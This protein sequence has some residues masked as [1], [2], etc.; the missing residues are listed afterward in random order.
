MEFARKAQAL[1]EKFHEGQKYG[2]Y[3][4][5]QGH[6]LPVSSTALM[7]AEG[8]N[9]TTYQLA[10]V[11][12]AA[13]LHDVVEDTPCTLVDIRNIPSS[14]AELSEIVWALTKEEHLTN[15]SYLG[16]VVQGGLMSILIKLADSMCNHRASLIDGNLKRSL[17]YARNIYYLNNALEL[18][19][20]KSR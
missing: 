8:L 18:E 6:L 10:L 7:I 17:K 16:K 9:F 13:W 14:P 5:L 15:A 11:E 20:E 12:A 1:A 3:S 4:Y 19:F 2:E